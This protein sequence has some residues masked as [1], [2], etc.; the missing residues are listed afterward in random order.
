MQAFMNRNLEIIPRSHGCRNDNA[1]PAC[2]YTTDQSAQR[3][4]QP[5]LTVLAF[6]YGGYVLLHQACSP[7]LGKYKLRHNILL[8]VE[9]SN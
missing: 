5:C 7:D 1:A 3:E 2:A 6:D 4:A 8:D 9:G